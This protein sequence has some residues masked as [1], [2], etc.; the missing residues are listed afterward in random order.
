MSWYQ[1]LGNTS[2]GRSSHPGGLVM[3]RQSHHPT[4]NDFSNAFDEPR[5]WRAQ[6]R[7]L[8]TRLFLYMN[9]R[10]TTVMDRKYQKA[11]ALL[12]R[13][14]AVCRLSRMA[15]NKDEVLRQIELFARIFSSNFFSLKLNFSPS[16]KKTTEYSFEDFL[17]INKI[18]LTFVVFACFATTRVTMRFRAENARYSTGL[19]QMYATSYW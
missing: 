12:V 4:G 16:T 9:G 6:T 11:L 2:D 15:N 14:E 3:L 1:T 17:S 8:D 18:V 13:N 7:G 5:T 10:K 19:Y